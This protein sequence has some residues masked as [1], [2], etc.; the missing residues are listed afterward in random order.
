MQADDLRSTSPSPEELLKAIDQ[1]PA[2]AREALE[3]VRAAVARS[4]APGAPG[5]PAFLEEA[6]GRLDSRHAPPATSHRRLVGPALVAAKRGFRLV[7][8]PFINEVLRRQVEF[9]EAIL[10]ALAQLT[11]QV[12]AN[13]RAQALWRAELEEKLE[14]VAHVRPP[15]DSSGT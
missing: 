12:Q 1:L 10:N 6:R 9:N 5:W 4:Q 14:R 7:A 13:A 8:Q 15:S 11:E 2:P 3:E